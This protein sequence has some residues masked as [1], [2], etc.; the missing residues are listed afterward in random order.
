MPERGESYRGI[1]LP[2]ETKATI[3]S[4]FLN[5]WESGGRGREV[6]GQRVLDATQK[7][8]PNLQLPSIQSVNNIIGP[9]RTMLLSGEGSAD[10]TLDRPWSLTSHMQSRDSNAEKLEG[11]TT[12]N[13]TV[14]DRCLPAL[15]F[16]QKELIAGRY[17]G[18]MDL[19]LSQRYWE[20]EDYAKI[21]IR[22]AG[23]FSMLYGLFD[24][25]EWDN[26]MYTEGYYQMTAPQCWELSRQYAR[27][28]QLAEIEKT[29]PITWDLDAELTKQLAV[30]DEKET[31]FRGAYSE[32]RLIKHLGLLP[33]VPDV[34]ASLTPWNSSQYYAESN[35][36]TWA[37][38]TNSSYSAP[39]LKYSYMLYHSFYNRDWS[40]SFAYQ[41]EIPESTAYEF[42]RNIDYIKGLAYHYSKVDIGDAE[43]TKH[44]METLQAMRNV[45]R[46]LPDV[47]TSN[48][49]MDFKPIQLL[50]GKEGPC[51]AYNS[52]GDKET[53]TTFQITF[54]FYEMLEAQLP[55][56]N[57]D[58]SNKRVTNK[59]QQKAQRLLLN[60]NQ[61]IEHVLICKNQGC[62]TVRHELGIYDVGPNERALA[63]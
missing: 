36:S 29:E 53:G 3:K 42:L 5:M 54:S 57:I 52:S 15:M 35:E 40:H 34:I 46:Y 22:E 63:S 60:I 9:L 44:H 41:S 16:L 49:D 43:E 17:F 26:S 55:P 8:N 7:S 13:R 31:L 24:F 21:T 37:A 59:T 10:S 56:S 58:E 20:R 32:D 19:K 33:D 14:D 62:S 18:L 48:L 61:V 12:I 51:L 30:T 25:K 39:P 1:G 38:D 4:V 47:S 2:E 27:R 50:E 28:E 6:S 45:E 23:W 11:E